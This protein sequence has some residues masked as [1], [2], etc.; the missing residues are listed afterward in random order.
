[1]PR[2][3]K[4]FL[5]SD[6]LL[7][8]I[9][10]DPTQIH[11]IVMNLC[12]NAFHAMREEGGVLG[13]LLN[14]VVVNENDRDSGLNIAAGNYL[15][16]EVRDT[17]HGMGQ[18]IQEKIFEPYFTT[19]SVGD[20][21]GLGLA[22]TYGIIESHNGLI[23]VFS[24]PGKGAVFKVF[25]PAAGEVITKGNGA[26]S[27]GLLRGDGAH[28]MI[29]DDEEQLL[30]VLAEY[31]SE[32][33]YRVSSYGS[34]L[35]AWETF[36]K[37]PTEYDLLLTDMAMPGLDGKA[38]AE[39]VLHLRPRMPVIINTGFSS[40]FNREEALAMGVAAYLQKPIS[41]DLMLTTIKRVL[42]ER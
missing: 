20:G 40:L 13:V 7:G 2:S 14:D 18:E 24:E 21:T 9:K 23:E 34:G 4:K 39:K 6:S 25:F 33:G 29:V 16:L 28:L 22:V 5:F 8:T 41:I 26:D 30:E 3:E 37:Q 15:L 35:A 12:T 10:G 27:P 36:Q 42:A 1:M 32:S 38:L 31:L 19:K 11:Q 17:G